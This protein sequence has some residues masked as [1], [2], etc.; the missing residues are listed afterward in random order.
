VPISPPLTLRLRF[1][2]RLAPLVERGGPLATDL[3]R[4]LEAECADRLRALG[5]PAVP[6]TEVAVDATQSEPFRWFVDDRECRYPEDLPR[7][8]WT[9]IQG[10]FAGSPTAQDP[11]WFDDLQSGIGAGRAATEQSIQFFRLFARAVIEQR[12]SALLAPA[13]TQTY[14]SMLRDGFP[15]LPGNLE[16]WLGPVLGDALDMGL[17][18]ADAESVA[19]ILRSGGPALPPRDHAEALIAG[20]APET[21]DILAGREFIERF[22]VALAEGERQLSLLRDRAFAELGVRYP[23]FRLVVA[24]ALP[25]R[26][27]TFRI[28][29]W[30]TVPRIGLAADE[31]LVYETADRLRLLNIVAERTT[32]PLTGKE[33]SIAKD[34]D[35]SALERLGFTIWDEQGYLALWL[36]AELRRR[37]SRF[38]TTGFVDD[39]L[40]LLDDAY[41][42]LV[43]RA[44]E[45][46]GVAQIARILRRLAAEQISVRNLRGILEIL[47]EFDW[48]PCDPSHRILFDDRMPI[49]WASEGNWID[50]A[51]TLADF[52]RTRLKRLISHQNAQDGSVAVVLL[53]TETERLLAEHRARGTAVPETTTERLIAALGA[54]LNKLHASAPVPALLT[55]IEARFPLRSLIEARFPQLRVLCRQ[56]LLPD[57]NIEPIARVGLD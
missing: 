17:S 11:A 25:E 12:P 57:I 45:K 52:V 6:T 32:H 22:S 27:F 20:L 7:A 36:D 23:G 44:R 9:F 40:G 28:Q 34:S 26:A 46:F 14:A 19:G 53:D 41:P 13:P 47:L 50:D 43:A 37:S 10:R 15:D 39:D 2:P 18:L 51:S 29:A 38:V 1:G 21:I 24:D 8:I 48:I 55:T 42:V 54:E 16:E 56:E 4:A 35:R 5:V 3:R 31:L 30:M 49:G 33:C